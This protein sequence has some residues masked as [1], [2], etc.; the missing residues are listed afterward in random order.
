M[1]ESTVAATFC[2]TLVDEW[3]RGGVT[4]AVVAPGSRSTPVTVALARHPRIRV[5]VH[6][7]ERSAG[8][9]ALGLGLA[10]GRPAVV[11][12][13]SGTAAVELHPAVVEADLAGV[14]L[15]VCTTDRPPELHGVGA[16]Q[17]VDQAALYGRS[18]RSMVEPGVPRADAAWSWRSLAAR[19]VLDAMGPRP[20]P[21]HLN[22]AFSEPLLADP[23]PLPA[24]RQVGAP[25]H[26]RAE[27]PPPLSVLDDLR[28][29]RGVIVAGRGS[30]PAVVRPLAEAYGWPVLA[31][32]LGGCRTPGPTTIAAFDL[33]ARTSGWAESHRPET[34]VRIGA[35]PASKALAAWL[36]D[37]PI[38]V[39]VDPTG[40]F[41]DPDR[42]ATHLVTGHLAGDNQAPAPASWLGSWRQADDAV[43]AVL[44]AELTG[45]LDDPT[46]ARS[47]VGSLPPGS[48]L[49]V[50]SSMPIRDVEWF[51]GTTEARVLANRGANGIDGVVSTAVG[52]A[53]AGRP[54]VA[55]VGD[56]AF[57]HDTNALLGAVARGLSLTVVVVD[58]DG[59]AIFSFLPQASAM[60]ADEFE[61][62]F[63]TPHGLDLVALA[64]AHGVDAAPV[65]SIADLAAVVADPQPGIRVRVVRTDRHANVAVHQRLYD[66]VAEAL[67]ELA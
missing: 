8:F 45:S 17:T 60:D 4:D 19:A 29:L 6:L 56:L 49:L 11:V 13:T 18:V 26:Q 52:V 58:N 16:P 59:G 5:H 64:A 61:R 25:W 48:D 47:V 55:L 34:V 53:L 42:L 41:A 65:D 7:D 40:A 30:E 9:M 12:T 28:G 66:R 63:G 33:L 21:V 50:A 35:P 23:G 32:P 3:A 46:V 10:T 2:A 20:G 44:A 57:L 43:Q 15:L 36:R 1:D 54:T 24:G 67:A 27:N 37:V 14:P 39:A 38:Q 22:L 31:D 62:L 51:G